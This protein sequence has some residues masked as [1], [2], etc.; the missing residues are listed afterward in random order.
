MQRDPRNIER[1]RVELRSGSA[2]TR[3]AATQDL[4][5]WVRTDSLIAAEALPLFREVLQSDADPWTLISAA[6]GI[7]RISGGEAGRAA[8]LALLDRPQPAV[9]ATAVVNLDGHISIDRLF[10]LCARA[11]DPGLRRTLVTALGQTKNPRAFDLLVAAL[12]DEDVRPW[13]IEALVEI[14]LVAAVEHIEPYLR[15]T[16]DAW[17]EDNHGPMM[18]V[19]DVAG[20]AI[21]RL[22]TSAS[23]SSVS[24]RPATL[25]AAPQVTPPAFARPG[26]PGLP[27]WIS[28]SPTLLASI[29]LA[30]AIL[31]VPWF[32]MF[33]VGVIGA[34][35]TGRQT[36]D[37]TRAMDFVA[38]IP[39]MI[40]LAMGIH[41]LVKRRVRGAPRLALLLFGCLSCA[42]VAWPF[43][44]EA[45]S[46]TL[47][48]KRE[49]TNAT[50]AT[51]NSPP[52]R[53][54]MPSGKPPPLDVRQP[55]MP[56]LEQRP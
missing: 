51:P 16:G 49:T 56:K 9:V 1:I 15:D 41:A 48:E 14:G 53:V 50:S 42:L 39:P 38:I 19:C 7:E 25:R 10:D 4:C 17:L 46:I 3:R 44:A 45:R 6:R 36:P 5:D 47:A 26:L 23:Q 11:T 2:D 54:P 34:T 21:T 37:R 29:P 33:A 30:A 27:R 12:N 22:R 43:L 55:E 40:G 28:S 35:G 8:L 52:K 24:D 13:A 32:L 31:T 20:Q 18:R